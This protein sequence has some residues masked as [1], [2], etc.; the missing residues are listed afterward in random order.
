MSSKKCAF[1][2]EKSRNAAEHVR[3]LF[4]SNGED[5]DMMVEESDTFLKGL[6]KTELDA[7]VYEFSVF[8]GI[9][10]HFPKNQLTKAISEIEFN[11]ASYRVPGKTVQLGMRRGL[12]RGGDVENESNV[13]Q[14]NVGQS[15][16]GQSNV[17][18]SNVDNLLGT[19]AG[20]AIGALMTDQDV[21]NANS[22]KEK[23]VK[24]LNNIHV[25]NDETRMNE[26]LTTLGERL[27]SQDNNSFFIFTQSQLG[28][29]RVIV[30]QMGI[31]ARIKIQNLIDAIQKMKG[32]GGGSSS[33]GSTLL[34][35]SNS[36]SNRGRSRSRGRARSRS[37][38][39]R[40]HAGHVGPQGR[41]IVSSTMRVAAAL[42]IP[43]SKT[44]FFQTLIWMA[45]I[46]MAGYSSQTDGGFIK[47]GLSQINSGNCEGGWGAFDWQRHP[48]CTA[49]KAFKSPVITAMNDIYRLDRDGYIKLLTGLGGMGMV[50]LIVNS[51]IYW[52]AYIMD[53]QIT[54]M[55][56][57]YLN[58]PF[59]KPRVEQTGLFSLFSLYMRIMNPIQVLK[60]VRTIMGE[61]MLSRSGRSRS[62]RSRHSR[63]RSSGRS[64]GRSGRSRHSSRSNVADLVS[65]AQ[66]Q[67]LSNLASQ[68]QRQRQPLATRSP[69]P[70]S[71]PRRRANSSSNSGSNRNSRRGSTRGSSRGSSRVA[72]RGSRRDARRGSRRGYNSG[73][74]S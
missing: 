16:V 68:R 67:A 3:A 10:H 46:T 9:I 40:R 6:S 27:Q 62:R 56:S 20:N 23:I 2:A 71:L 28:Q 72:R 47:A 29:L 52:L 55:I 39:R 58:I 4:K 41:G 14:S 37:G 7:M 66:L 30:E 25:D 59:V 11:K 19:A 26:A 57:A 17:G 64:S 69:S 61:N 50:P 51:F 38:S 18:Q 60:W 22:N 70:V 21:N 13:G 63:S 48:L 36:N 73:S 1:N 8:A 31:E 5:F 35:N 54:L 15:N 34:D 24:I 43:R 12:F 32:M 45:I 42:L 33:N 53:Y 65:V 74:N 44:R 49:W